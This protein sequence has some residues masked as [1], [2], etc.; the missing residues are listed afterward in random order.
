MTVALIMLILF[1]IE[2][3]YNVDYIFYKSIRH[4]LLTTLLPKVKIHELYQLN[5]E[6]IVTEFQNMVRSG[7]PPLAKNSKN[8]DNDELALIPDPEFRRLAATVD[9]N[10]VLPLYNIY[11]YIR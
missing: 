2:I 5:V 10:K 7:P 1:L 11:R 3:R 6:K 4:A 9:M 8:D